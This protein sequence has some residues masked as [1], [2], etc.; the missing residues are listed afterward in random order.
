[1]HAAAPSTMSS[2]TSLSRGIL[3]R[4]VHLAVN[5]PCDDLLILIRLSFKRDFRP[6]DHTLL[7]WYSHSSVS[8]RGI[9]ED[10]LEE[11]ELSPTAYHSA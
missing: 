5:L 2:V 4:I 1:M 10:L 8:V 7:F 9:I 6:N 11:D 3:S